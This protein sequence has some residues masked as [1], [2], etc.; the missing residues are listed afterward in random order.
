MKNKVLLA[1]LLVLMATIGSAESTWKEMRTVLR[2]PEQSLKGLVLQ[3][4]EKVTEIVNFQLKDLP[5]RRMLRVT[6]GIK[7]PVPFANRGE[8]LFRKAEYLIDDN[9]DSTVTKRER[10]SLYFKGNNDVFERLAYQRIPG[11]LLKPGELVVTI[12]VV[13]KIGL[14]VD[15]CQHGNFGLKIG[16]YFQMEGRNELDIYD[17]PDS[18]LYLPVPEGNSHA[19]QISK[20]FILPPKVACAILQLGGTHFKGECWVEAPRFQQKHRNVCSLSFTKFDE[21]TD[22]INY[23]VGTNLSTRSW[24]MWRLQAD[25]KTIF[26]GN[27]FDRASNVADFYIQLPKNLNNPS[28]LTL[29]LVKESHRATFPYEIR[30]LEIIEET[31]RDFEVIS[32]PRYVAKKS[33]FG[34]LVETNEPDVTLCITGQGA[35]MPSAQICHFKKP[36]LHVV[37]MRAAEAGASIELSFQRKGDQTGRKE[38]AFVQQV[39]DKEAENIYVSSGDEIYIDKVYGAYDYFFKWYMANRVGNWYQFRPSYQW[40]GFRV[41]NDEVIHHYTDL[42]NQLKVPYAWQVEGRTLASSKINPSADVLASPMFRGKQAHENDG[43]YYYWTHFKYEGL[44]SDLSARVRPYG[45]IF[46]KH[47]PI[48]T[49]HGTFIHYD[50]SGLASMAEGA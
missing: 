49:N 22:S 24:P 12:P 47:R 17:Q 42:L 29:Q 26:E 33:A 40:S 38:V 28:E 35:V 20:T 30:S 3:P 10:Y 41:E 14:D 8:T 4:G 34:V 13:K 44:F 7:M 9:L 32:V 23:W 2:G 18:V 25:G 39:I 50:T 11:H 43:G 19:Q 37:E 27:I 21:R 15:E 1:S 36:G 31:A 16:L 48:Y 5:A 6:G 46:A 45:G